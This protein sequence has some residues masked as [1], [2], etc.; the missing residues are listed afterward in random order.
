VVEGAEQ[1]KKARGCS[2]KVPDAPSFFLPLTR[3]VKFARQRLIDD[4]RTELGGFHG[5]WTP[6]PG[7]EGIFVELVVENHSACVLHLK[8]DANAGAQ[9]VHLSRSEEFIPAGPPFRVRFVVTPPAGWVGPLE[10][11][12]S[13][14]LVAGGG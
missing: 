6:R 13:W 10:F 8:L 11:K 9:P 3:T 12:P 4:N 5:T 2:G 7:K 1:A 14:E